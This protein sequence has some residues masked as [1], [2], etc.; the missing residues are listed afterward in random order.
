[1]STAAGFL[2]LAT[3]RFQ[4]DEESTAGVQSERP[5][6]KRQSGVVDVDGRPATGGALVTWARAWDVTNI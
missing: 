2:R 5:R 1:M 3:A 6:R 4:A